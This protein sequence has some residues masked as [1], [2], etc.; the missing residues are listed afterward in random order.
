[1]TSFAELGLST[2]ILRALETE[3][4]TTP[5]PIQAQAIP[6]ILQGRDLQGIAQTGTGKTA[7][8]A[9]PILH[10]LAAD[11]RPADAPRLPRAR[12]VADA[13]AGQPDRR[14]LPRL[15]PAHRAAHHADVRRRAEG[16]AGQGD[17]RRHRHPRRDPRPPARPHAG[18]RG[19]PGRRRDPGARRGRSH[20]RPRLHRADPQD[21]QPYLRPSG[22]PCSSRR[23]CRRR[24]PSSPAACCA[25]RCTS[26][27]PR[28]RPRPSGS[29]RR[30]SSSRPR[31]SGRCWPRSC[32]TSAW[33]ARW[34]S[35]APSTAPTR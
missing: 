8:F 9:T 14:E 17:R 13:R 7:A 6:H 33:S 24:S 27:S 2:P 11:K 29:S 10:R 20:A 3:G 30:S 34:C 31:A 4:Y 23:P 19:Q 5:T 21:R 16:A 18:R 12:A 26:P 25:T 15:W 22:R 35:P 1:M 28:W 32:A